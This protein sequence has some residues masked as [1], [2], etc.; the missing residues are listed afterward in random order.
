MIVAAVCLALG[1]II[2][3]LCGVVHLLSK[4]E[5]NT[6]DSLVEI[7]DLRLTSRARVKRARL[8]TGVPDEEDQLVRLGRVA[9]PRRVIFGGDNDSELNRVLAGLPE[10]EDEA[11]NG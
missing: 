8:K 9:Q 1:L 10:P 2:A 4:I 5:R 3:L 6:R 11:A 7:R